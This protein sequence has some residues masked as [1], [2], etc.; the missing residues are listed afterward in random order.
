M[1]NRLRLLSIDINDY[2]LFENNLKLSLLTG[3]RVTPDH[4]DSLMNLFGSNYTNNITAI[5]G[6]NATGKTTLL[7]LAIGI[8]SLLFTDKSQGSFI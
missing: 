2:P 4:T 6:K 7:K 1:K 5:V 8:L 3:N